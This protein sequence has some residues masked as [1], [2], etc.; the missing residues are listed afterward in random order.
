MLL[1]CGFTRHALS[2]CTVKQAQALCHVCQLNVKPVTLLVLE[3]SGH[4]RAVC[5]IGKVTGVRCHS[6]WV[7]SGSRVAR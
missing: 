2:A 3:G 6:A 4:Q 5:C 7:G 1:C